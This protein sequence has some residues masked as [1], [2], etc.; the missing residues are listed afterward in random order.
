MAL[1]EE[2]GDIVM[3]S[4][5]RI[6]LRIVSSANEVLLRDWQKMSAVM[7]AEMSRE[8]PDFDA[9]ALRRIGDTAL[10]EKLHP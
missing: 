6:A 1:S 10:S 7:F 2:E 4:A 3:L 9:S 8:W 5:K